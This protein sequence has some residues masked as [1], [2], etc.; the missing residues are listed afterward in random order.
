MFAAAG[1]GRP[2]QTSFGRDPR[3]QTA[4]SS[5]WR[6]PWAW[7][8]S[9]SSWQP[10]SRVPR[11][12]GGD[13]PASSRQLHVPSRVPGRHRM[14]SGYCGTL[15]TP[16]AAELHL[17]PA[18]LLELKDPDG[19]IRVQA[20]PGA[21]SSRATSC[22]CTRS[23]FGKSSRETSAQG[24][25]RLVDGAS[26]ISARGRSAGVD[27]YARLT[28]ELAEEP[29]QPN[30]SWWHRQLHDPIGIDGGPK[31]PGTTARRPPRRPKRKRS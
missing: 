29:L 25:P 31:N 28:E 15:M 18:A 19:V 11:D 4:S 20:P 10:R 9:R 23:C 12:D 6:T 30:D 14:L 13:R 8:S 26:R 24:L 16:M 2:W 3:R 27:D 5:S 7:P 1:V 22:S 17:V 21:F